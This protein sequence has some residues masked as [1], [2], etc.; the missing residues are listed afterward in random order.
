MGLWQLSLYFKVIFMNKE[1]DQRYP[2]THACDHIRMLAGHNRGGTKLSRADA[3]RLRSFFAE[4]MSVDDRE[5]ACKIADIELS[6][7]DEERTKYSRRA[8]VE[9]GL[10]PE[11]TRI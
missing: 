2:Y 3:S 4:V 6:M 5:L 1:D 7:S 8:L 9:M 11:D 10:L